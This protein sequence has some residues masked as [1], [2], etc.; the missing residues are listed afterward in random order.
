M[1]WDE[2]LLLR[3]LDLLAV[4]GRSCGHLVERLPLVLVHLERSCLLLMDQRLDRARIV[5]HVEK[6]LLLEGLLRYHLRVALVQVGHLVMRLRLRMVV[7]D[8]LRGH[9]GSIV[10]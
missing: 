10:A 8:R 2:R 4:E 5:G 9:V 1:A 6:L 7:S 3:E